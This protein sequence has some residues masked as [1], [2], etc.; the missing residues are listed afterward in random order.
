MTREREREREREMLVSIKEE[1]DDAATVQHSAENRHDERD[2]N[3]THSNMKIIEAAI[4]EEGDV[5]VHQ[6]REDERDVNLILENAEKKSKSTIKEEGNVK[7]LQ[8]PEKHHN[9]RVALEN[10]EET[11]IDAIIV[12][13]IH[14]YNEMSGRTVSS[15]DNINYE[16]N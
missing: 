15:S 10:R 13:D 1:G 9:K 8:S 5:L 7:V 14:N 2:V 3:F 12:R 4:E 6:S 11:E 16:L